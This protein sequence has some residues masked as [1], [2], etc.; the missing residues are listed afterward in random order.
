[1]GLV[2]QMGGGV[3]GGCLWTHGQMDTRGSQSAFVGVVFSCSLF[4]FFFFIPISYSMAH[5]HP[6]F[7]LSFSFFFADQ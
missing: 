6:Q 1:M 4:F 3:A 7:I 2:W 5:M